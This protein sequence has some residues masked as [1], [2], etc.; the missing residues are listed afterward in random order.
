MHPRKGSLICDKY[1]KI[2]EL[3]N[4]MTEMKSESK[5]NCEEIL[6]EKSFWALSLSEL[7]KENEIKMIN[8]NIKIEECFHLFFIQT[9]L[10]YDY[11]SKDKCI[12]S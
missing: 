6:A 9:K 5:P 10:K 4:R 11:N 12:I 8:E 3:I 1:E 2:F 7:T